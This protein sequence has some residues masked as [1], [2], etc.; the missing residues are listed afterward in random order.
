MNLSMRHSTGNKDI[1][2]NINVG[3]YVKGKRT[4]SR[5]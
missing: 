2:Q 1:E 3:A 4:K 5:L